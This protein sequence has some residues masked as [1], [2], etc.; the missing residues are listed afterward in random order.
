M[1]GKNK[2][3]SFNKSKKFKVQISNVKSSS[4]SKWQKFE[5]WILDFELSYLD[6]ILKRCIIKTRLLK[7]KPYV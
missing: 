3:Y 5:L 6:Y 1:R 4:K 2:N 7:N